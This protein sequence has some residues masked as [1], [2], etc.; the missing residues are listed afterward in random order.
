MKMLNRR[1]RLRQNSYAMSVGNHPLLS[2]AGLLFI[3]LIGLALI[4]GGSNEIGRLGVIPLRALSIVAIAYVVLSNK[5]QVPEYTRVLLLILG[6]AF[7]I[8]A[9]Q[10]IPLPPD[11]WASLPG[12]EDYAL[13][14]TAASVE[15]VWR[16]IAIS[17]DRTIN[18]MLA[19][20]PLIA[21][22][23]LS[24]IMVEKSRQILIWVVVIVACLSAALG[25]LQAA[26][27]NPLFSLYTDRVTGHS[28]GF[29]ANRNHQAV[30]LAMV[31]PLLGA[32][33]MDEKSSLKPQ[34]RK[35]LVLI[36]GSVLVIGILISKSRAGITLLIP[37]VILLL[38]LMRAVNWPTLILG[39]LTIIGL[40]FGFGFAERFIG[41]DIGEDAR[42]RFAPVVWEIL[43]DHFPV[44]VGFG[45]FDPAFRKAEPYEELTFNY[46]NH[47]HNDWLELVIEG[48]I[49]AAILAAVA[50]G[51]LIW[52][53]WHSWKPLQ[54]PHSD[55]TVSRLRYA[56]T[57]SAALIFVVAA[58]LLDYPM[59]APL[60]AV[61]ASI[62]GVLLA[63]HMNDR[64]KNSG[65]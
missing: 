23:M 5:V 27:Y 21:A 59:R 37:A 25:L 41:A 38:L 18:S 34:T 24:S 46:F 50:L 3:G 16:P 31:L 49:L 43:G 1:K 10:L 63:R 58:S 64:S 26:T 32:W 7:L 53:T 17:P 55:R 33:A 62:F 30:M 35:L 36:L 9:L 51:W 39:G 20:L 44:G 13:L 42:F 8:P 47:A 12:R 14:A 40:A 61:I 22:V 2:I 48:G 56:K 52:S 65:A 54:K 6:A 57:S 11:L 28:T 29:F 19:V 45:G 15:Q 60:F 4:G